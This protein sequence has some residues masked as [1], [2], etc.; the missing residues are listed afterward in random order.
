MPGIGSAIG[1]QGA[2]SGSLGVG[3]RPK[4]DSQSPPPMKTLVYNPAARIIIARGNRQYDV[5]SDLV[6]GGVVRPKSFAAMLDAL[7]A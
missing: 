7:G 3:G 1:M 5:S 4:I 6:N 2:V